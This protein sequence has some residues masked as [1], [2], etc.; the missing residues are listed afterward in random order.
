[1]SEQGVS[2]VYFDPFSI[3]ADD[4]KTNLTNQTYTVAQ[5]LCMLRTRCKKFDWKKPYPISILKKDNSLCQSILDALYVVIDARSYNDVWEESILAGWE[6][7]D[8]V[9]RIFSN[10]FT[11]NTCID[12]LLTLT[13]NPNCN[14]ALYVETLLTSEERM[15]FIPILKDKKF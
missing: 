4:S 10:R 2:D 13:Y 14:L 9:K 8:T 5:S 11:W 1:M 3:E 6:V 12:A 15:I 7:P